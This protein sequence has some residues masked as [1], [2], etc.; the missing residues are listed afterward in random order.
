YLPPTDS[1]LRPNKHAFKR[2][3]WEKANKHKGELEDYQRLTRRKRETGE[4]PKHQPR[5]FL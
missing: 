2:G 3:A 4:L 5:W 1:R